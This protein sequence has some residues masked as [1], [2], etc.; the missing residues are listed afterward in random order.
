MKPFLVVC[1]LIGTVSAMATASMVEFDQT[2]PKSQVQVCIEAPLA[3][4]VKAFI[5][6]CQSPTYAETYAGLIY[7]P[8]P[9]LQ[10]ALGAGNET[11]GD[12]IGGWIWAG[13]GKF[14]YAYAFEDGFTGQFCKATVKYTATDKLKLGVADNSALGYGLLAEY[15]L[16]KSLTMVYT[17]YKEPRISLILSF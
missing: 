4:K 14:S 12:R 8:T 10:L 15:K 5:F 1:A 9:N 3:T 7:S 2:G 17:G 13:L 6:T 11:G 16:S